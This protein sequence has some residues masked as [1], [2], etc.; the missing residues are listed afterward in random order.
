MHA[1][2]F[3]HVNVCLFTFTKLTT[4]HYPHPLTNDPVSFSLE[5]VSSVLESNVHI[6]SL[7]KG[8]CNN[9]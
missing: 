6:Y 4:S 2:V 9:S 5:N 3:V 1:G 8:N 7:T